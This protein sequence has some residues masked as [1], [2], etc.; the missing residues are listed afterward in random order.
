MVNFYRKLTVFRTICQIAVLCSAA[1][2]AFCLKGEITIHTCTVT[3]KVP[4]FL[5]AELLIVAAIC[6]VLLYNAWNH[7]WNIP[8]KIRSLIITVKNNNGEKQLIRS[9]YYS[10]SPWSCNLTCKPF[11]H[12]LHNSSIAQLVFQAFISEQCK[13]WPTLKKCGN[14]ML[15]VS[16]LVGLGHLYLAK[17]Y[18]Q[19][20]CC[21]EEISELLSAIHHSTNDVAQII[22]T[23]LF[24]AFLRNLNQVA[25]RFCEIEHILSNKQMSIL[26]SEHAQILPASYKNAYNLDNQ[27]IHA[28]CFMATQWPEEIGIKKMLSLLRDYPYIEIFNQIVLVNTTLNLLELY[29]KIEQNFGRIKKEPAHFFILAKAATMAGLTGEAHCYIKV[30]TKTWFPLIS[31]QVNRLHEDL[32]QKSTSLKDASVN[33]DVYECQHCKNQLSFW[34]SYCS[35]CG[36]L[37]TMK[38]VVIT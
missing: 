28:V 5:V 37:Y 7:I 24:L 31:P 6:I 16:S 29:N 19:S 38:W 22:K 27:N 1:C 11:F 9:V 33:K 36:E 30:M 4:I 21:N 3:K 26:F 18:R 15:S 8:K 2:W 25:D 32:I 17:A 12:L 13:D 23:Q 20:N 34:R 14:A 10:I 35:Q